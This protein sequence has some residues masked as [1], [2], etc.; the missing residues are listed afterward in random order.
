MLAEFTSGYSV[1]NVLRYESGSGRLNET[2]SFVL[3]LQI[4][5]LFCKCFRSNSSCNTLRISTI[6][7]EYECS[8][9]FLINF[10]CFEYQQT[11]SY[12][13]FVYF[14]LHYSGAAHALCTLTFSK[15]IRFES[16]IRKH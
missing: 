13:L 4:F 8:R 1:Q 6:E 16:K 10:S 11:R 9:L 15:E 3:D 2:G 14:M 7:I 12:V 5:F